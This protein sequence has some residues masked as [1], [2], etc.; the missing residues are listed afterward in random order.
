M[1]GSVKAAAI[2]RSLDAT[3]FLDISA[4]LLSSRTLRRAILKAGGGS[5]FFYLSQIAGRLVDLPLLETDIE[6][7]IS[8]DGTVL[9]SAS[10]ALRRFRLDIRTAQGRL[11]EKVNSILSSSQY[12]SVIQDAIVTLRDGRY[13]IPIKSDFKGQMRGIIHDSSASGQTVYM[14]PLAIV[15]M[16]NH[17]R[18][19]QMQ[20][21]EEIERVLL[22]LAGK[23]RTA[24]SGDR[25]GSRGSGRDRFGLCQSALCQY[26]ASYPADPSASRGA[27]RV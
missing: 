27:V 11:L 12:H 5:S 21:R 18:E 6:Q 13:V 23:G 17:W 3:A 16:N 24:Q 26:L 14:E 2:G 20:E 19:L 8:P 9:D 10:P 7:T 4:T 1:R 22:E 15:D 25:R